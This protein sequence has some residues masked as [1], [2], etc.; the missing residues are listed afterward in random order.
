M[1]K[2]LYGM[3]IGFAGTAALTAWFGGRIHA[4]LRA[5]TDALMA[6]QTRAAWGEQL[7]A[8]GALAASCAH[9]LGTPLG[10]IA[11]AAEEMPAALEGGALED[12][13]DD[14]A[15][16][17]SEVQRC[18][19]VLNRLANDAGEARGESQVRFD[20]HACLRDLIAS[21]PEPERVQLEGASASVSGYPLALARIVRALL[22]NGR[23][24][25]PDDVIVRLH[26][27]ADGIEIQVRDTGR[28]MSSEI[29]GR[30]TEPFFSTRQTDGLGLGL[31][32]AARIAEQLGGILL[33]ESALGEGTVARLQ[34]P[35][36]VHD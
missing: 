18:R 8:L 12:V 4:E 24:A 27:T 3:W 26:P 31:Y 19:A 20:V 30:A 23:R 15:L 25:G 5:R 6:A 10:S 33:L 7:A 28:G 1:S 17:Q 11:I 2:H 16:I 35:W 32:L 22:D 34:L 13:R 29:L 21:E 9:E 36:G 14:I